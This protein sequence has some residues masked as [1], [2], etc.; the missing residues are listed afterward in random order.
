MNLLILDFDFN[1]I[2]RNNVHKVCDIKSVRIKM[3]SQ[4][5]QILAFFRAISMIFNFCFI[6]LIDIL[7][8]KFNLSELLLYL[9]I[10]MFLVLFLKQGQDLHIIN[11]QKQIFPQI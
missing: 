11:E 4:R 2:I 1:K 10:S 5:A 3:V 8:P 6:A 9:S 7:Y